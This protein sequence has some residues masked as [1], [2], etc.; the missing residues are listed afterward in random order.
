MALFYYIDNDGQKQGPITAQHLQTLAAQGVITPTTPLETDT[1]HKGMAGQIPG[2]FATS[3]PPFAPPLQTVP[4]PTHLFCTNCGSPTSKQ[5]VVCTSCGARPVGHKRFCRQCGATLNPEQVVCIKC[6]TRLTTGYTDNL[7]N[8]STAFVSMSSIKKISGLVVAV[9]F[10]GALLLLLHIGGVKL[11]PIAT[12]MAPLEFTAAEQAEVDDFISAYGSNVE[13]TVGETGQSLLTF[14]VST[15]QSSAVVH[16]LIFQG[17]DVNAQDRNGESPLHWAASN[18]E[19]VEVAK[20]LVFHGADV[21]ARDING[22]TPFD[23]A[24]AEGNKVVAEY[25]SGLKR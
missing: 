10:V 21:N 12:K 4:P 5:S 1:G 18:N 16:Y 19:S 9:G 8:L 15:Y 6:S 20:L 25:L 7:R 11:T 17:A 13:K 14:A 22:M 2:L 24:M 3:S 23:R